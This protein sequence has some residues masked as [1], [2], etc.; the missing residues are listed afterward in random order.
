MLLYNIK[1]KRKNKLLI[2]LT[3]FLFSLLPTL[4]NARSLDA[5][6][7]YISSGI[8]VQK[9]RLTIIAEN[10]ANLTTQEDEETGLPW[11]KRYAVLVPGV[12]GV[13]IK[14]IEKS[15]EPFGKYYDPAVPQSNAE[16][17][18]SYPNVN[19]PDEM[20]NLAYTEVM[21]EANITA[22]KTTKSIYKNFIDI[23]R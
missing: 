3:L 8:V 6:F 7:T 11:Q 10:L 23:M 19:L 17:F 21:F 20:V 22:F 13:R 12:D 4:A 16:G 14:S 1:L 5:A 9:M 18:T 15:D 2:I